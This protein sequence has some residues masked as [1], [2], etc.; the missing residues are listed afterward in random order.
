[1]LLFHRA[2]GRI[3]GFLDAQ[4]LSFLEVF[5]FRVESVRR[6]PGPYESLG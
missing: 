1:M 2:L 5:A 6:S 3:D 4:S